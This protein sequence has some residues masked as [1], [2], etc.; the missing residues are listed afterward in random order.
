M[1]LLLEAALNG[2]RSPAEHP[3]MPVSPTQLS[4]ATAEA[5][6]AGARAVHFH[7]RGGDGRESLAAAFLAN[8]Q[9]KEAIEHYKRFVTE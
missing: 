7:V 5:A 8:G 3:A 9:S 2:G 4:A 6:R 1:D